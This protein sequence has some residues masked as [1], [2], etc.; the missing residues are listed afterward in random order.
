MLYDSTDKKAESYDYNEKAAKE[1]GK[2]IANGYE[3]IA[4]LFEK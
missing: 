1:S 4:H 2:F 3:G